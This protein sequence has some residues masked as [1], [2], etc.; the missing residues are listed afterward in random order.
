MCKILSNLN[1]YELVLLSN[2][3]E[4][5]QRNRLKEMGINDFFIEYYGESII[6]PY[7]EAY[8]NAAGVHKPSECIIIGDNKLL[9]IDIP[10]KLGFNTI[11]VH[12]KGDIKHIDDLSLSL[13]KK[14][15]KSL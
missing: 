13:I 11:Y 15:E 5:S 6:K 14:I 3:F 7:N 8:Q 4:A 2:F 1:D 12:K 10:K 9:D